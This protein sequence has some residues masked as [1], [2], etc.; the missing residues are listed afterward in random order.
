MWSMAFWMFFTYKLSFLLNFYF[1]IGT[2]SQE[3][4]EMMKKYGSKSIALL[5]SLIMVFS[6]FAPVAAS[7]QEW[8]HD[9]HTHKD[10]PINYVSIGDSMVNGYGLDGY[11]LEDGTNVNGF[12]QEVPGSYPVLFK[13]YLEEKS[14]S[15]VDLTQLATS[16]L[17]AEDIWYIITYDSTT[18]TAVWPGDA[19]SEFRHDVWS[20]TGENKVSNYTG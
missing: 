15:T 16:A 9:N 2:D 1:L 10:G 3:G 19:Y 18:N 13:K 11:E 6:I 17:R 7:A 8:V 12:L 14:G 4:T 5:M 20:G